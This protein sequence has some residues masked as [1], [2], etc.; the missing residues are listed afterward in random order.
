MKN[1]LLLILLVL[2]TTTCRNINT[3][4]DQWDLIHDSILIQDME[5]QDNE[6]LNDDEE[7]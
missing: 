7:R 1:Y 3:N 4:R 5:E 6:A 2:N